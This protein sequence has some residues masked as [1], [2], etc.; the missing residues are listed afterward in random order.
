MQSRKSLHCSRTYTKW[1]FIW[2][3]LS[4]NAQ[5]SISMRAFSPEHSLLSRMHKMGVHMAYSFSETHTRL[6]IHAVSPDP[7]LL[8]HMHINGRICD[9]FFQPMLRLEEACMQA[10]QSLHYSRTC[11]KWAY[12]WHIPSVNAQ[13]RLSI[14]AVSPEPSLLSNMHTNGRIYD[15]FFQ[16]MRRLEVTCMLSCQ[17][18]HCSHTC[19]KWA[20][21]WHIISVNAQ[22]RLSLH[23]SRVCTKWAYI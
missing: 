18:L 14:H 12:I 9:I 4:V 1:V 19:T 5:T 23:C 10:C 17:C 22:T 20:Y 6:S 13:T 11:T 16:P 2:H 7:S 15:I 3:I 21:I 8:S